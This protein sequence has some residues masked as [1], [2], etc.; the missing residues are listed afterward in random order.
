MAP[1]LPKCTKDQPVEIFSA[2]T[3]LAVPS[4]PYN[5]YPEVFPAHKNGE[6]PP[7]RPKMNQYIDHKDPS[8]IVK[9]RPIKHKQGFLNQLY[10][11]LR[12][13]EASVRVY[14]IA[15][16]SACAMFMILKID[17]AEE[18]RFLHDLVA[19]NR[20][21]NI[22]PTNIPNQSSIINT[23]ARYSFSSKIDHS[24]GYPNIRIHPSNDKHN[25]CIT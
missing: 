12:Q 2:S 3:I 15:D 1:H 6:L 24:D 13:E 7:L 18:A 8:L 25:A 16:G 17:K 23:I 11:K 22:E 5:Q 19:T 10:T 14:K 20:T 9:P 4:T 21:T